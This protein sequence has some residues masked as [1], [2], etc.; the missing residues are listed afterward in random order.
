MPKL[1]TPL[2]AVKVTSIYKNAPLPGRMALA[3]PDMGAAL[4]KVVRDLRTLGHDLR[5][6]DMFRSYEMQWQAHQDYA[7]RKKKA[8][9]PPPGGSM[10]EGGRA[11]DI[12]LSSMGVPLSKFWEIAKAHGFSPIIDKPEASRSEAWHFDCRGSHNAVYEYVRSGKAGAAMPPYTQMASSAIAA[13]GVE[14]DAVHDQD[15]A[16]LQ[17]SLIRLGLDPGRIDGV[18]GDRTT[19]ALKEAGASPD[20]PAGALCALLKE[21]FP[22]EF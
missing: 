14:L 6:S 2:V 5:L 18:M 8:Y 1:L 3:T 22:L 10:H 16:F 11:I 21:K 20:D 7:T 4:D 17:S 12:D 15:V 9:S 13:I 19:G